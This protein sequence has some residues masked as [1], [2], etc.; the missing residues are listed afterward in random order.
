MSKNKL[1]EIKEQTEELVKKTNQKID[2]LGSHSNILY[3]S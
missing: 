1:K 3:E 2:E